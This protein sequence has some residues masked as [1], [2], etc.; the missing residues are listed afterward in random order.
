MVSSALQSSAA[1]VHSAMEAE[2]GSLGT[3]SLAR[4]GGVTFLRALGAPE[5]AAR[6]P[7]DLGA[8]LC[9]GATESHTVVASGLARLRYAL[10]KTS[11]ANGAPSLD[12]H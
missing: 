4:L 6:A 7:R 9:S 5:C 2:R 1:G 8:T 10:Q 3:G 12:S 11:A